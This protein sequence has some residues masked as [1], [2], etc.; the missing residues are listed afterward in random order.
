MTHFSGPQGPAH[1]PGP[2]GLTCANQPSGACWV[3]LG[4]VFL[5]VER[6]V[7]T[8]HAADG[9]LFLSG[10]PRW[11]GGRA[12][13]RARWGGGR[14][15]RPPRGPGID[16][17]SMGSQPTPLSRAPALHRCLPSGQAGGRAGCPLHINHTAPAWLGAAL[18]MWLS[19]SPTPPR[20]PGSTGVSNGLSPVWCSLPG[21]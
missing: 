17:G 18:R 15:E 7:C 16:S 2:G 3:N 21:P 14:P 4:P 6:N 9:P 1:R 5:F 13:C 10:A 8:E 19:P 11:P 20:G 12:S